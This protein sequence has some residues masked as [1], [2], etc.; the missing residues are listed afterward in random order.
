MAY[1]PTIWETGDV[2]TADKLNKIE[3]GLAAA[4]TLVDH[5][6]V[7]LHADA[8]G[9]LDRTWQDIADLIDDGKA[10]FVDL[11]ALVDVGLVGQVIDA[12]T[13]SDANSGNTF[14]VRVYCHYCAKNLYATCTAYTD[15]PVIEEDEDSGSGGIMPT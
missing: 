12:S 3:Q 4:E 13:Y 5:P 15:Y 6:I 10:V 2:I 11:H 8:E 1:E 14:Q 7:V 9:A